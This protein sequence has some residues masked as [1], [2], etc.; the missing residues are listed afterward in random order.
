MI[1]NMR[2]LAP[3]AIS[4]HLVVKQSVAFP[5]VKQRKQK[6]VDRDTARE[7]VER[8]KA[9][10]TT[11]RSQPEGLNGFFAPIGSNYQPDL[12][13]KPTVRTRSS[14]ISAVRSADDLPSAVD[15]TSA[16]AGDPASSP[17]KR[18]K[19]KKKTKK[20]RQDEDDESPRKKRKK[21][22]SQ[23]ADADSSQI[24]VDA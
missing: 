10:G 7:A 21:R 3:V 13:K 15:V 12:S 23:T 24:A 5:A 22:A 2:Y 17:I 19:T 14:L 4:R 9:D 11:T 16:T 8:E 18:E 20:T 6:D 1:F